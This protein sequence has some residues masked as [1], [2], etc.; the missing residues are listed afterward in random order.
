[1]SF[2]QYDLPLLLGISQ[3]EFKIFWGPFLKEFFLVASLFWKVHDWHEPP[4]NMKR[5]TINALNWAGTKTLYVLCPC[6]FLLNIALLQ[7]P[8]NLWIDASQTNELLRGWIIHGFKKQ[9]L[10]ICM[11]DHLNCW[12][13]LIGTEMFETKVCTGS[14][15]L[16]TL[17]ICI[18]KWWWTYIKPCNIC[19][20]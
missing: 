12:S 18:L 5:T 10:L 15:C 6:F 13:I 3:T 14:D 20:I 8:L 11:A 2:T 17:K 9:N 4:T 16:G 7:W 19:I 1:M